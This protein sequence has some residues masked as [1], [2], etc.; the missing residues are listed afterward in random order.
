MAFTISFTSIEDPFGKLLLAVAERQGEQESDDRVDTSATRS[1]G[2]LTWG[3]QQTVLRGGLIRP[4]DVLYGRIQ[5][6]F[7]VNT[8]RTLH[9]LY[10]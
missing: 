2:S 3:F 1:A 7:K 5:K 8:K 6:V 9:V 4:S 10:R